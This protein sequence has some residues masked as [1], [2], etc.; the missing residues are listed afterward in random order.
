M[1]IVIIIILVIVLIAVTLLLG[2]KCI[3]YK[4]GLAAYL[5]YFFEDQ[6]MKEPT[7]EK[8]KEYQKWAIQKMMDDFFRSK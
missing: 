5:R 3:A 2:I 6:N 4:S 1:E 7:S 8:L